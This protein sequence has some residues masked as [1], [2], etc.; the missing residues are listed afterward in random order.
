MLLDDL[1]NQEEGLNSRPL[2]ADATLE[3]A[4][5]AVARSPIISAEPLSAA[6]PR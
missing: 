3:I 1:M 4:P 2:R 5:V 6:R